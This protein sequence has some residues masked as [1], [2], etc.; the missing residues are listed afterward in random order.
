MLLID[1][2]LFLLKAIGE[3]Y[4]PDSTELNLFEPIQGKTSY[5]LVHPTPSHPNPT[6]SGEYIRLAYRSVN[7]RPLRDVSGDVVL[8]T[9]AGRYS[10]WVCVG[11]SLRVLKFELVTLR[12]S[13]FH[14]NH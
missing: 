5:L 13:G 10:Y 7:P 6:Y 1:V 14:L 4:F 8:V 11:I 2:V 12:A 3:V 9:G